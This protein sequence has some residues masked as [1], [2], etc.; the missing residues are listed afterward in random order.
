[1]QMDRKNRMAVSLVALMVL[2]WVA[3]GTHFYLFVTSGGL[4]RLVEY[5]R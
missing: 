4:T 5:L 2:A 1:M 3:V